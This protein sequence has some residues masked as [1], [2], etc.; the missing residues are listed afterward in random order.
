[1]SNLADRLITHQ[2]AIFAILANAEAM[3]TDPARRDIPALATARWALIREFTAYQL[4]KHGGLLDPAIARA[5]PAEAGRLARL[6]QSGIEVVDAFRGNVIRWSAVD[7][8]G[9]WAE[10]QAS[11]LAMIARMRAQVTVEQDAIMALLKQ[12]A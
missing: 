9:V 11:A 10:Y 3:L 1:M 2:K 12:A 6:K 8:A 7:V 5:S 4:L